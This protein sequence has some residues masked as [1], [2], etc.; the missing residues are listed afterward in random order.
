M[1][2]RVKE[3]AKAINFA[4][5]SQRLEPLISYFMIDSTEVL[6]ETRKVWLFIASCHIQ[7]INS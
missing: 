6:V 3:L 4:E 1:K 7:S 2:V 5:P